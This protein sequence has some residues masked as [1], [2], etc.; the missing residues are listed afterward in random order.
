MSIQERH[1]LNLGVMRGC[2]RHLLIIGISPSYNDWVYHGEP[3]KLHRD[4]ERF[5]EETSSNSFHEENE[6]LGMLNDLQAPIEHEEE[7]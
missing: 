1:E 5:D 2:G 7:T 4:I 3:V 6:M